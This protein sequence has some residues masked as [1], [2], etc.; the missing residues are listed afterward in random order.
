MKHLLRL[1]FLFTV[2]SAFA[3]PISVSTTQTP[4]QLVDNVLLG[5][6]VTAFNVTINGNLP[7]PIQ[8]KAM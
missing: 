7:S 6:G 4:Q 8:R 1:L 5:F 3:Q 2:G